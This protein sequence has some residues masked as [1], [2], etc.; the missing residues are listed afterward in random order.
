M[1]VVEPLIVILQLV[2]KK[3]LH[4]SAVVRI[5]AKR[6]AMRTH[7][8]VRRFDSRGG[9]RLLLFADYKLRSIFKS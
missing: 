2:S 7:T 9:D 3:S 6:E 8:G 5:P 1:Y 4:Y